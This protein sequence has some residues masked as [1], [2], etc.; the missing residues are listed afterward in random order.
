MR[1]AVIN[2]QPKLAHQGFIIIAIFVGFDLFSSLVITSILSDLQQSFKQQRHA[3]EIMQ[4]TSKVMIEE[5]R[6]WLKQVEAAGTVTGK[7]EVESLTKSA[8]WLLRK[9]PS[10]AKGKQETE[11]IG[12]ITEIAGEIERMSDI[13]G[14]GRASEAMMFKYFMAV[15]DMFNAISDLNAFESAEVDRHERDSAAK[16]DALQWVVGGTVCLNALIALALIVQFNQTTAHSLASLQRNMRNLA[17]REPLIQPL[18]GTDELSE[19][20]NAFY[21]MA[22]SLQNAVRKQQAIID[23][24][25]DVICS[26][27]AEGFFQTVNPAARRVWGYDPDDLVEQS[28]LTV[29]HPDDCADADARLREIVKSRKPGSFEVRVQTSSSQPIDTS[30]VA[31]WSDLEETL[32]CV[33]HDV[34]ER[35]RM[36]RL[37]QEFV[38]MVSHDLRTPLTAIHGFLTLLSEGRYG[39]DDKLKQ[40]SKQA[41]E[42]AD[43]LIRLI[44]DLLQLQKAETGHIV[45]ELAP[46]RLQQIISLSIVAVEELAERAGIEIDS[47]EVN[48]DVLVDQ[49]RIVQVLVNLLS[50]AIKF[51]PAGT[52]I[53]IAAAVDKR[54]S[55]L[56]RLSVTDK[57]RGIPAEHQEA[58]FDKFYQVQA[59]DEKRKGGTGLGL[60]ISKAIVEEH[61]GTM[62]VTSKLDQGSTFWLTL[63]V[64]AQRAADVPER[65][66]QASSA[67]D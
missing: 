35:K 34:S 30:W 11:K 59:G 51:S 57:G 13:I 50:N 38:G 46:C 14:A 5:G 22:E 26:I 1:T 53:V 24:S 6:I 61:G 36:E 16:R 67:H 33:I 25:A 27:D 7:P 39:Q 23:N 66:R 20:N 40:R 45:L 32:Y 21:S 49:D 55:H 48:I 56:V 42:S 60:A 19:I 28:W 65:E 64:V 58:I 29:I 15:N 3:K 4:V 47:P 52:K 41:A 8:V 43:R 54:Q 37:K 44:N 2:L 62:G 17:R 31:H 63:P 18:P 9:L 12:K 10:Q